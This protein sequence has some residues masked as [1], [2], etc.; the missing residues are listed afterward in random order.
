M[1][2]GN[3]NASRKPL[4]VVIDT[5]IWRSQLLLK[6]PVGLSLIYA[7]QR[8]SGFLGLPE[9][10]EAELIDQVVEVGLEEAEK[11][12]NSFRKVRTLT[13]SPFDVPVPTKA[14]LEK[15]V[16]ERLAELKPI[17]V[18]V[19]FTFE[20]AKAALNMVIAKLPPN[21]PEHQQFK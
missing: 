11:L 15:K 1:T 2:I 5:N 20:H 6:T 4:C 12:A 10:V 8:Q 21:R 14:E 9:V 19:P 13:D 18:R 7:L 17:I 16:K 3:D